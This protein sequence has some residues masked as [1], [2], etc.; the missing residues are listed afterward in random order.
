MTKTIFL[1]KYKHVNNTNHV[2][3]HHCHCLP[4][5]KIQNIYDKVVKDKV[6]VLLCCS[7]FL[8]QNVRKQRKLITSLYGIGNS[9]YIEF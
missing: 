1:H 8:G 7:L 4:N 2:N 5:A 3:Y 9:V 6:N